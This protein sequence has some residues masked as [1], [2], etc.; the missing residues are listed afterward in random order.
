MVSV[1]Y[2]GR[3][4]LV[5]IHTQATNKTTAQLLYSHNVGRNLNNEVFIIDI[6]LWCLHCKHL[7]STSDVSQ[8]LQRVTV[9][10][11]NIITLFYGL[12]LR[13]SFIHSPV[14]HQLTVTG[15]TRT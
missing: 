14:N 7:T 1:N 3:I 13:R 12:V 2:L 6:C 8:N 15:L 10:T 9:V 4:Q 5:K 11:D